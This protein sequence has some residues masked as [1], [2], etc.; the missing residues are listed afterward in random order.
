MHITQVR[1]TDP[2]MY[3]EPAELMFLASIKSKVDFGTSI[4]RPTVSLT[5]GRVSMSTA[6]MITPLL[7]IPLNFRRS[8]YYLKGEFTVV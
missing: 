6:S 7:R 1:V 3:D 8:Q 2:E 4:H 5:H